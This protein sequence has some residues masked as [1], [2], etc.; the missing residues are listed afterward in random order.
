NCF[1]HELPEQ[2]TRAFDVV[3]LSDVFEHIS[4][5]G[6]ML[7]AAA[8]ALKPDGVLYVKVP[9]AKWSLFKQ[10]MLAAAGRRP[11]HGLWDAYEHVVH[12]TDRTLRAML[13]RHGFRVLTMSDALPVQTPNWHEHVGHYYQYPT[14]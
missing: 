1:L 8:R 3:A 5:P 6:E 13:S 10:R 4:Q 9:N 14:P 11:A 7:R 2:E 12:Y